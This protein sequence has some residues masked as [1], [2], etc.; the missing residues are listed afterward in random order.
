M[1]V[2]VGVNGRISP[3]IGAMVVT[4]AVT[5]AATAAA[6]VDRARWHRLAD[7]ISQGYP[8][9]SLSR[10]DRAVTAYLL[11][12]TGATLLGLLGWGLSIWATATRRSWDRWATSATF[13]VWSV[14]AL[15]GLLAKDTSGD[16]GLVPLLAWLQVVPLLPAALAVALTW[17]RR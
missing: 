15:V 9:Y 13:V 7:H 11:I 8:G 10:V 16:V 4:A 5:V 12:L 3:A 2:G 17:R 1:G 14:L 6:Y